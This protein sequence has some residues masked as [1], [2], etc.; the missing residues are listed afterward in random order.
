[1][2]RRMQPVPAFLAIIL[3][4]A[5]LLGQA[6][7]LERLPA[8][9]NFEAHRIT[10]ADP[11]GGNEDWRFLEPGGTLV[12]ADISG[13]GCIVHIRDNITS[14]E[15]HHLQYHTLRMYW[16]G[17]TEPSV[18]APVGDFFGIGFGFT[19]KLNSALVCIDQRPGRLTDPAAMGAARNCYFPM[20]FGKSA[21]ITLTN[22][23]KQRSQHW[24]EVNYRSYQSAPTNQLCFHAQYRQG[25]PPPASPYLILDAKGRGHLVGCVLS[26][27]NNDGGWWGEGDEILYIDGKHAMQGTG[28]EDYF[29]E[30]YGLRAGCF[31]YFGVPL[32]EEPFTSA[33]RWH[34]PDPV[35]FRESLRFLIEQGNGAPPFQ[36]HN[37]YYSVAYWYQTEPHATFPTLPTPAE[38]VSWAA[39]R[40][41]LK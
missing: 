8:A 41:E 29:C 30:S 37:F 35:P 21:R 23:G 17:E 7:S 33:Y 31:P 12:L 39:S 10:S 20:P 9:C 3:T 38:R 26:V 28:S 6:P 27:K 14:K 16:D 13:P 34:V 4:P 15:P 2:L 36:S 24:F 40:P 5:S 32:L 1:M 18:E 22:E 11:K 19:E 25:T